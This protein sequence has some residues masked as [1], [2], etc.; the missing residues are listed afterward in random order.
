MTGGDLDVLMEGIQAVSVH[1]RTERLYSA[2]VTADEEELLPGDLTEAAGQPRKS[3][4]DRKPR[5]LLGSG[6]RRT[7]PVIV[8]R[9]LMDWT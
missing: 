1:P 8:L 5:A 3:C 2:D 4:V 9:S 7:W 6:H